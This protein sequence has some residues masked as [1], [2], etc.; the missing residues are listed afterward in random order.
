MILITCT[1]PVEPV[2][3]NIITGEDVI[4]CNS[5]QFTITTAPNININF[6]YEVLAK[7]TGGFTGSLIELDS[8]NGNF[9]KT[10]SKF[11][12]ILNTKLKIITT[13]GSSGIK[14]YKIII[15][16]NEGNPVTTDIATFTNLIFSLKN[17]SDSNIIQSLELIA[18]YP[19]PEDTSTT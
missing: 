16:A 17:N 5:N 6:E 15:C 12:N 10:I 2:M 13:S 1:T 7:G 8:P 14:Y 9:V 18:Y 3:S 11:S 19:V 4:S